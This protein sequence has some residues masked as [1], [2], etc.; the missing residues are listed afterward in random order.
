VRSQA[1]ATSH[2]LA[3]PLPAGVRTPPPALPANAGKRAAQ[4]DE[5]MIVDGVVVQI[6]YGDVANG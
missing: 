5:T 4:A 1:D 3:P 6:E 2:P